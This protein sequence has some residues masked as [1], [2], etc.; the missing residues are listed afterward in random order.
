MTIVMAISVL[1]SLA[2]IRRILMATSVLKVCNITKRF[3]GTLVHILV[4]WEDY[5]N[6]PYFSIGALVFIWEQCV[7]AA[8]QKYM[9]FSNSIMQR[10]LQR[11]LI[12]FFFFC[13]AG[14]CKGHW[15]GSST[16]NIPYHAVYSPCNI[17]HVLVFSS[18]SFIQFRSDPP[19]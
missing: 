7:A 6:T 18:S 17:L 8:N 3:N 15:R 9:E 11:S 1:S 14:C 19:E 4:C 16:D 10:L 5:L 13:H 2:I 12:T